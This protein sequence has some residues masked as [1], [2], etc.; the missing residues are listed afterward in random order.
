MHGDAHQSNLILRPD[1]RV[2]LIDLERFAFGHPESDLAVTA[3]EHLIGWHTDAAVRRA[4]A[5]PTGMTCARW[6][7]F[8]VIR[9]I[10]ELKMTTWLMQN[11][12][13]E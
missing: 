7:G 3:T 8:P 5:T 4:S 1:G 9:A 2:I 10:N 11:V 13:R 6:D 12:R